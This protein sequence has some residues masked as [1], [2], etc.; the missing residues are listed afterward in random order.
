MN[1]A[2]AKQFIAVGDLIDKAPLVQGLHGI[3]KSEVVHQYA[4]ENGN[5]HFEPLIL[6]LMDTGDLLGLPRTV[7]VG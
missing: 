1:I 6:S 5:M 3:G 7:E 4:K 2:E